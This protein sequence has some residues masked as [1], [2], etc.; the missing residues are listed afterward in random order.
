MGLSGQANRFSCQHAL[1]S[2]DQ[3]TVEV[4]I[5]GASI[6]EMQERDGEVAGYPTGE[7]H[8]TVG[9][10]QG[11]SARLCGKIYSPVTAVA[12]DWR[13]VGDD[14]TLKWNPGAPDDEERNKGRRH[15]GNVRVRW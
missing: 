11:F 7:S 9:Q 15:G 4:R 2:F 6:S 10:G 1:A 3:H 12:T 14:R 8:D 13:K 5:A